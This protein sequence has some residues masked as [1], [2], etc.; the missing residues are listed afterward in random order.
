MS[1]Y[2]VINDEAVYSFVLL[3][4]RPNLDASRD[5]VLRLTGVELKA[6]HEVIRA[7]VAQGLKPS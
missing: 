3:G 2:D 5:Y 1:R 7:K 6:L 4:D